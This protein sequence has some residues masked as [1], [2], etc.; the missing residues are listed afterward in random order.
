ME[1]IAGKEDMDFNKQWLDFHNNCLILSEN[2][3]SLIPFSKYTE[4][5]KKRRN[6]N[7]SIRYEKQSVYFF[8]LNYK[9]LFRLV[10]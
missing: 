10:L 6:F 8:S 2:F 7:N 1:N 9:F 3:G 5:Q 4:P